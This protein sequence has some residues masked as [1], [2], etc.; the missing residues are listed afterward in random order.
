MNFRSL[1]VDSMR[2]LVVT[3]FISQFFRIV[4]SL[5]VIRN[6]ESEHMGYVA[7]ALTITG[8]VE[9]FSSM[10][11]TSAIIKKPDLSSRDIS[12][13]SGMILLI[14]LAIAAVLFG[15]SGLV[16]AFYNTPE[17]E[18]ILKVEALGF[19]LLGFTAVPA[20]LMTKEMRFKELGLIQVFASFSG[21]MTSLYLV[22]H[23]YT[24][25]SIVFGGLVFFGVRSISII[26][27]SGKFIIP[28]LSLH[29]SREH[30]SFGSYV[31]MAGI[32][33]YLYTT[34][35][36]VIGG[37][38]WSPEI[39]GIY[40]VAVQM[41]VMPLSRIAPLLKQ[42]AL[43]AFSRS[44]VL[45]NDKF[46]PYL[47][48]SLKISMGVCVPLYL[49]LSSVAWVFVPVILGDTWRAAAL[50]LMCLC[51]G[52]PFRL[53]LELLAPPMIASGQPRQ[54]VLNNVRITVVMTI[55]FLLTAFSF[56]QPVALALVWMIAFPA[57]SLW[58]SGEYCKAMNVEFKQVIMAI[59]GSLIY[60]LIMWIIVQGFVL[61][62]KD[63]MAEWLVLILGVILGAG[64]YF[65][66][67]YF[68]D[69]SL[70]KELVG[71]IRS[72]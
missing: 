54:I 28:S 17:V 38:F 57:L 64:V 7:L 24:Y 66:L 36:V 56:Q 26:I 35:D 55:C 13:I 10:G 67:T 1:V 33:W 52:A 22:T 5:F 14:N 51:F 45:N 2:W 8:F 32:T 39:L 70:I 47:V 34:L 65:L 59:R 50:P 37:W 11:M 4:V 53:Y 20:A 16:A 61:L 27:L 46:Q 29:E 62:T 21:A 44:M 12:N 48:K 41:I 71:M 63:V 25:W 30:L 19:I 58:V 23:G 6:L 15:V 18:N 49:G 40:A 31:M 68:F 43:P 72:R 60:S 9:M 42:V 3:Q 69:K